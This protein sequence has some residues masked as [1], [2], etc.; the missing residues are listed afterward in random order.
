VPVNLAPPVVILENYDT[1]RFRVEVVLKSDLSQ[2]AV[3]NIQIRIGDMDGIFQNT[4]AP[5]TP[6]YPT[7]ATLESI[8]LPAN[9]IRSGLTNVR[10]EGQ[11]AFN[12]PNPFNPNKTGTTLVYFSQSVGQ[13]N[14]KIFTITGSLV[15]TLTDTANA[16][17]NEVA[18]DGKNGKG[19]I[20]RNGVYVAVIKPPAGGKQMVKIAVVK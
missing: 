15:R 1:R 3:K 20:V 7:N 2:A 4:P 14:I 6:L 10:V 19:Q 16:G 9:Y 18:W 17:S 8:L 11:E 5:G 12:Y 13:A